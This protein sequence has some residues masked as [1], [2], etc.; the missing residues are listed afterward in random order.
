MSDPDI[1]ELIDH[2]SRTSALSEDEAGRVVAEVMAYFNEDIE[3]F[4]RRRHRQMQLQG[5]T[6]TAIYAAIRH[7]LTGRLFP[8]NEFSERQIRRMI[9]G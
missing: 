8:P 2:L 6:N 5:M 9:Y 4:I 3:T 1:T 7:E